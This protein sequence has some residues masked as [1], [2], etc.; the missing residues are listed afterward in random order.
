MERA[1]GAAGP[2]CACFNFSTNVNDPKDILVAETCR[3]D[4]LR[5]QAVLDKPAEPAFDR[6]TKLAARVLAT[7]VALVSFVE[8]DRQWFKSALGLPEPYATLRETPLSLS[9]CKTVVAT[10]SALVIEDARLDP[11]VAGNLAIRDLGVIAYL[12]VPLV[13]ESGVGV[14]A[15]AAGLAPASGCQVPSDSSGIRRRAMDPGPSIRFSRDS[16]PP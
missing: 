10:R 9:F 5:R 1:C 12:G 6:L 13:S 15:L 4:E 7:P 3:L 2:V 14:H 11:R 16:E 8:Q